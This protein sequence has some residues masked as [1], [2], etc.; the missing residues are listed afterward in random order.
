[1]KKPLPVLISIPHGGTAIP[2]EIEKDVCISHNDI[3]VDGDTFAAELFD[4]YGYAQHIIIARTAR[5]IVDVNRA[6]DD[7][8]HDGVVKHTTC[9]GKP[10]YDDSKRP[11]KATVQTLLENSYFPYHQQITDSIKQNAAQLKLGIDCHTMAEFAPPVDKKQG[12]KRPA[13][14]ISNCNNTRCPRSILLKVRRCLAQA[15]SINEED[16]NVNDTFSGGYIVQTYGNNPIPWVQI[17]LNRNLYLEKPA[18]P[19]GAVSKNT[20]KI[21]ECRRKFQSA[22]EMFFYK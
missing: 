17:E 3:L 18:G 15:F 11:G 1:M 21:A 13:L 8:G 6:F 4:L 20:R 2:P 22:L 16:I 12:Q 10:V 5:A 7:F 19:D 9:Y 14:C